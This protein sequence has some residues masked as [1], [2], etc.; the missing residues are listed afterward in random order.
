VRVVFMGTPEFAVPSLEALTSDADVVGVFT[1]SDSVSGRGGKLRP[2]SVKRLA[3]DNAIPVFEPRTLRDDTVLESLAA[4]TPDVLVVAAYGLIL[5]RAVLDVAPL[6]A[7]NVHASLL[8]RW[9]GAAP[10]QRAILAGDDVTGVSIMRMEEGLD[11][12][13]YCRQ[14][15][16]PIAEKSAS[17]LTD[18]LAQLGADALIGALPEIADGTAT[19]TAQD[20]SLVTY[21]E[22]IAKADVAIAPD[23]LAADALRRIRASNSAAPCRIALGDKNVTLIEAGWPVMTA[24]SSSSDAAPAPAASTC[25]S[26]ASGPAAPPPGSLARSREG[27]LIG[28]TNGALLVTRVKPDGKAEMSAADWARGLR[29]LDDLSWNGL[30]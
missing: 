12:G 5:P 6:G 8:P 10:I 24:D 26:A 14:A 29:D 18:E 22:K 2:S 27:L 19:W 17:A 3:L 13:P 9:R 11:T 21:A 15:S 1:R 7:M 25:L 16:T 30:R 28:A 23:M 20:D 4:L